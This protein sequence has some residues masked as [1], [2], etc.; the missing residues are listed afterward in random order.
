[1]QITQQAPSIQFTTYT[2]YWT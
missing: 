2:A 1:M